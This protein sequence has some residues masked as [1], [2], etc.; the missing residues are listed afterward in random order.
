MAM[1]NNQRVI[2]RIFH[3][4]SSSYEGVPPLMETLCDAC[5]TMWLLDMSIRRLRALSSELR[6]WERCRQARGQR[7]FLV[8]LLRPWTAVNR[9]PDLKAWKN[10]ESCRKLWWVS[11]FWR[12][13]LTVIVAVQSPIARG[14]NAW[15]F[16][17]NLDSCWAS[18]F[19]Q[20]ATSLLLLKSNSPSLLGWTQFCS[21]NSGLATAFRSAHLFFGVGD[22]VLPWV[23]HVGCY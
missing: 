5:P 19:L 10:T 9:Y 11:L 18:F 14:W 15:V 2:N 1:L 8:R 17:I 7:G 12:R 6:R 23:K 21:G 3:Y 4:R 22:A 16:E 20:K 13:T